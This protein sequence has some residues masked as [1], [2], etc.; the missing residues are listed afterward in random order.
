MGW[1][2]VPIG[3]LILAEPL[4]ELPPLG[5]PTFQS[6]PTHLPPLRWRP[7][8]PTQPSPPPSRV[9]PPTPIPTLLVP[10]PI[11]VTP[12]RVPHTTYAPHSRPP[13]PAPTPRALRGGHH[14]HPPPTVPH[15]SYPDEEGPKHWSSSRYEH[16]M[17][18]RQAALQSA[19]DMWAD[20]LLVW[21]HG[22]G[23]R[24]E[25]LGGVV[26]WGGCCLQNC[27]AHR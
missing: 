24:G 1:G 14:P 2:G 9:P 20:Y 18:L 6:H 17:K 10:S 22:E 11:P 26:L 12:T 13:S 5:V 3:F 25:I 16:V 7:L 27:S 23:A 8:H 19:R 4:F 21:L 15:S